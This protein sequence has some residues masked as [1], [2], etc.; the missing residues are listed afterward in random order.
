MAIDV[1]SLYNRRA[2]NRWDRTCV[3][4][5][6]E[7]L[8]WSRPDRVAITGWPGAFGDPTFERLTYRAADA[9][10][11]RVA[12]GLLAAGLQRGDRVLMICENFVEAYLTKFGTA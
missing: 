7:R 9:V 12:N 5:L 11:N 8:T 2:D 1:E 3:G 6:L 4:D 10:A